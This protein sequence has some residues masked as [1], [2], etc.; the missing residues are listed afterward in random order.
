VAHCWKS[1]S[2][3][4]T[5]LKN[6]VVNYSVAQNISPNETIKQRSVCMKNKELKQILAENVRIACQK[7]EINAI[8]LC[9]RSGVAPSEIS[10]LMNADKQ[11]RLETVEAVAE[12]LGIAPWILFMDHM[13]DKMI[14]EERVQDV[15]EIV[16]TFAR[17]SPDIKDSI[18]DR[19]RKLAELD[20]LRKS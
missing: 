4:A 14:G 3:L 15:Q 18:I 5:K 2:A 1:L 10:L 13:T 9:R 12:G 20:D 16:R 8:E 7:F 17:C 6:P 11:P 19:V